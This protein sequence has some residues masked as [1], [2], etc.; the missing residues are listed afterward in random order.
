MHIFRVVGVFVLLRKAYDTHYLP[1]VDKQTVLCIR[2]GTSFNGSPSSQPDQP[3]D[4]SAH[5]VSIMICKAAANSATIM[6]L[7]LQ[8][9]PFHATFNPSLGLDPAL[10]PLRDI[11]NQPL[12]TFVHEEQAAVRAHLID[13]FHEDSWPAR[14]ALT[15]RILRWKGTE[16]AVLGRFLV[17]G[18]F[19]GRGLAR[20]RWWRAGR[21]CYSRWL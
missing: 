10:D 8:P 5:R 20:W 9:H 21:G 14:I 18:I 13:I 15:L 1:A 17:F 7:G 11:S 19:H 3:A 16:L 4:L 12:I 2:K 6:N